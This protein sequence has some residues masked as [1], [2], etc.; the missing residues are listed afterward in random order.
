MAGPTGLLGE[1][2]ELRALASGEWSVL[3]SYRIFWKRNQARAA[4]AKPL[5]PRRSK[6]TT[7][8][9]KLIY[10]PGKEGLGERFYSAKGAGA[11]HQ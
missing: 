5:S 4:V 9:R 10:K 1:W 7:R 3:S 2:F 8:R 6:L 11:V